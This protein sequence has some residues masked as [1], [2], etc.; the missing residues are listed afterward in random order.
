M[1]EMNLVSKQPGPHAYKKATVG[2]LHIP[3]TLNL[4][5]TIELQNRVWRGDIT[6][7]WAAGRWQYVA[8]IIDLYGR[9]VVGWSLSDHPDAELVLKALDN[10]YETTGRP[11]GVMSH[12]DQGSQYG[13]RGFRQAAPVPPQFT[14][15]MGRRGNC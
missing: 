13:S 8:V 14:Q 12:S 1:R 5:F 10:A 3:N 7:I 15:R 2:R 4:A 9:R 11:Q 6:Y